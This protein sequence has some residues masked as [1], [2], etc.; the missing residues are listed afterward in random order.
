MTKTQL[1]KSLEGLH[2]DGYRWAYQ[3]CGFDQSLAKDVLQEVY[4]KILTGK[5]RYKGKSSL[6]TWFFSVIR[7]TSID[8]LKKNKVLQPLELA[9]E[10]VE[11]EHEDRK[12]YKVLLS[13]LSEKQAEV[14][15]LVFYHEHTLEQAAQVMGVSIGT[16]RIHYHRA[17]ENF[18]EIIKG[19][20]YG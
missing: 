19:A 4:V 16:A 7:F 15:L 9:N 14:L 1:I 5:A 6:K 11:N 17:K 2:N 13:R 3:C 10:V 12:D 18:K 8:Q 20:Y